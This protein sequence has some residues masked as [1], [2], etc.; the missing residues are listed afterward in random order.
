[1]LAPIENG[2]A[3]YFFGAS[4]AKRNFA[5]MLARICPEKGVHLAIDA[6]KRAA[7]PLIICGEV[8]PYATHRQYFETTV[9]PALDQLRRFIG[10][11][12]LA[13]KR[14]LLAMARCV[15]I[16]SLAPETSSLV[17]R[18]ALACGTPVIASARGALAETIEHGRTG[19]LVRDEVEMAKA[20]MDA[21]ALDGEV[22]RCSARQRYSLGR[23]NKS[24]LSVYETLSR[25]AISG[26]A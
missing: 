17:A 15:L 7:M 11:V 3:D 2:V 26:A 21:S 25:M 1:M 20:M 8:F 13:R 22:C 19:F 6:A 18:E 14:R 24:Y 10:P 4:A 9:K 23:T 16:P 5:L 12:G